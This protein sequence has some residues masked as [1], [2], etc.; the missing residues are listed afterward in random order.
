MVDVPNYDH[1]RPEGQG[2]VI[3][4]GRGPN[5][6]RKETAAMPSDPKQ[7]LDNVPRIA[8]LAKRGKKETN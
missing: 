3:L 1:Y 5:A 2:G 4:L 8:D 6:E 7:E